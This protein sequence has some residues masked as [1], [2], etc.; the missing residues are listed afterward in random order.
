MEP[1]QSEV[2][3][4]IAPLKKVTPLSK[5]LAM[6]LFIILPFL[7]GWIGYSLALVK[8]VEVERVVVLENAIKNVDIPTSEPITSPATTAPEIYISPNGFS[9]SIPEGSKVTEEPSEILSTT[10][11]KIKGDFGTLLI[12]PEYGIGGKGAEGAEVDTT[13]L[14]SQDGIEMNITIL[15]S[16]GSDAVTMIVQSLKPIPLGFTDS[17][18]IHVYTTDEKLSLAESILTSIKFLEQI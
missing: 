13:I 17:S 7:G 9:I 15:R 10:V 3:S 12:S 16:S 6:T 4:V 11:T 8:T 18:Q 14:A 5:Y 1:Q 2:E